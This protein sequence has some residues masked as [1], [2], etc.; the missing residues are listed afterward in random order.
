MIKRNIGSAIAILSALCIMLFASCSPSAGISETATLSVDAVSVS[1]STVIPGTLQPAKYTLQLF[2]GETERIDPVESTTGSFTVADVPIGT[3]RI[4]VTAKNSEGDDILKGEVNKF[5]VKPGNENNSVTIILDYIL[6][7]K[8]VLSVDIKWDGLTENN[9]VYAA[10][11]DYKNLGFRAVYAEGENKGKPINGVNNPESP[12]YIIWASSEDFSA[13][14]MNYTVEGLEPTEGTSIVFQIYTKID[15]SNQL[16]AETFPTVM[17]IYANLTSVPDGNELQNFSLDEDHI[18]S[19]LENVSNANAVPS[20]TDASTSLDIT[21]T[22]PTTYSE[23]NYPITV[24]VTAI[25]AETGEKISKTSNEYGK[26]DASGSLT[27]TGLTANQ[28][29][30]IS[31][32][33]LSSEGFSKD[34]VLLNGIRPKVNVTGIEFANTFAE[35]YIMGESV[36]IKANIIPDTATIKDY[37]ISVAN[38]HDGITPSE[39]GNIEFKTSGTYTITI[40]SKDNPSVTAT[41]NIKVR[42]AAPSNVHIDG[43]PSEAGAVIEWN[44]VESADGYTVIRSKDGAEDKTFDAKTAVTYTDTSLASGHTY[45]YAVIAYRTD[46][47]LNSDKSESTQEINVTNADISIQLPDNEVDFKNVLSQLSEQ[48]LTLGKN[49]SITITILS[50][51]K[52][53]AT[54][55]WVLNGNFNNPLASGSYSE[56]AALTIDDNTPGLKK[57]A[58]DGNTSNDLTLVVQAGSKKYSSTGSFTVI[59][60]NAAGNL[61]G[62]KLAD[63]SAI[64]EENSTVYYGSPIQLKAVFANESA[65]QPDVTWSSSNDSVMTVDQTGKVT[66]HQKGEP[67]TITVKSNDSGIS[68][69]VTLKPYVKATNVTL[70]G[71]E[72]TNIMILPHKGDYDESDDKFKMHGVIAY[73]SAKEMT[74]TTKIDSL[75]N[76]DISGTVS[77]DFDDS[78]ISFDSASGKITPLAAGSTTLTVKVD[79]NGE[80]ISDSILI[81]VYDLKMQYSKDGSWHDINETISW[82]YNFPENDTDIRISANNTE[83]IIQ[84]LRNNTTITWCFEANPDDTERGYGG[85]SHVVITGSNIDNGHFQRQWLV[86]SS[87]PHITALIYSN[88]NHIGT[89]GIIASK[90]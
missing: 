1:T 34:S 86:G 41:K 16:I 4:K 45:S 6:S 68:K 85:G 48:S 88:G 78:V 32:Q 72:E 12:D 21:W 61:E 27:L 65:D 71:C 49:E 33:V 55:S 62:I 54:Y 11:N 40:A 3:Y 24:K 58:A 74:T 51:I 14:K 70:L 15:G 69:E 76:K 66:T 39:S 80:Q 26:D 53:K 77:Y 25:D 23:S 75:D 79:N 60:N 29:Y 64:T 57:N 46:S 9:Q 7:G 67:V 8:G 35:S 38:G 87:E 63:G 37:T 42:L 18:I 5:T 30:N 20:A 13:K 73:G 10:I 2:Q 52:E 59:N 47:S 56:V 81:Y 84:H 43:T 90:R 19:Y 50:E 36:T 82:K 44:P 22:N 89:V 83:E 17:Q 31:F 28:L